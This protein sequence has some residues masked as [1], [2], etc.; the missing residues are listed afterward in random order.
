MKAGG[1]RSAWQHRRWRR[2]LLSTAVS[3]TGDFLYSVALVVYLIEETGSAG[4]VAAA[5]IA[6]MVAFTLLGAVGGV[7]A[8]RFDR[9]R[10]MVVLDVARAAVMVGIAFIIMADGP[11]LT[12]LVLVVTSAALTTPYR[13]AGVAA[14][15]LL[16]AED[17]LAAANA[18]EAS[19]SQLCWFLGPALGAAIVALSG[20]EAAFF[21]NAATFAVS[22]VLVAGLGSIGSGNRGDHE[23]GAGTHMVRE[24]VEGARAVKEV[25]GLA[26]LT[27]LVVAVLFAFGIEQVVQVLVVRDRLDLDADAVGVLIACT[28]IGGLLAVPF[29]ARLAAHRNAG[30]LLAISGLLMGAPLALLAVTN[31][32]AVAGALMVVE[33]VGNIFLDVLAIT[34]LQR[35]CPDRLLGRVFS[36]QDTSGSLAQL[37]GTISAPLL[38]SLVDLELALLVGGGALVASSLLL[39]PAL[40]A[41]S[42]RTEA[43]RV[44]LAPIVAE[45][46][47]LGILGDASQV[48][49]ER[50]ARSTSTLVVEPGSVIVAEGDAAADLFVI[51]SGTVTVSTA[52]L[53]H[54]RDMGPGEWFG[55]IG[56]IRRLPRTATVTAAS[57]VDLLVIPGPVFLDA[58]AASDTMA[59]PLAT[60]LNMRLAR[61]HP[62]LLDATS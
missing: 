52:E 33:G 5:V 10:L 58:V 57:A 34:L 7:I 60:A 48:A 6:R 35:V 24:F 37:A 39:L 38:I 51:R 21:A 42:T 61:T 59:G 13:P 22:A 18:A 16:V 20:P 44:R 47:E 36:L 45:L 3:G 46:G 28:G 17:D 54:V 15:P 55:E 29:S 25:K 43:E 27:L 56:L 32:L 49:R 23:T 14:T 62:H 9:R 41:I 50:I 4:W 11:P 53:G 8:D 1:F 2:F 31:H 19:I 26:A 40:Q 12:V 30:R